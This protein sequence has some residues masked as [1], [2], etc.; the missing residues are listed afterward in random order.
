MPFILKYLKLFR[1]KGNPQKDILPGREDGIQSGHVSR[2]TQLPLTYSKVGFR[3][4]EELT[5]EQIMEEIE[6]KQ[7]ADEEANCKRSIL[8]LLV[9]VMLYKIHGERPNPVESTT[10]LENI[11]KEY[12]NILDVEKI[13]N[14]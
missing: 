11:L 14:G 7:L 10:P 6:A 8:D 9:P 3:D 4:M 13:M 12:D 2:E 1:Y 5:T